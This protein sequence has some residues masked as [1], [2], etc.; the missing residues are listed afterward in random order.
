MSPTASRQEPGVEARGLAAEL[1]RRVVHEGAYANILWGHLLDRSSLAGRERAL[2]TDLAYGTIRRKGS[3]EWL[4]GRFLDR[5]PPRT[6]HA[7]LL[8][9]AYQI[10]FSAVP[11]HAAVSL[12]VEATPKRWKP[13]VNAVLRKVANRDDSWPD[14]ATELSY[15]Q[16]ILDVLG[17]DLGEQD[18]LDALRAMNDAPA[19]R[20]RNDG[21]IQDLSSEWVADAV[22]VAEGS[23]VVDLCAAPGGKATALANRK[24]RVLAVDRSRARLALVT[25]NARRVGY[26]SL[27]VTQADGRHPPLR[28]QRA[29]AV[30]VDAPCSGLGALRRRPDAR[31]RVEPH[32]VEEL[33][34][35]QGQLLA[36]A[37]DLVQ[38]GGL[39]VY[40]V[41]TLTDEET[42]QVHGAVAGALDGWEVLQPPRRWR[43]WGS[44]AAVLPQDHGTDGMYLLRLRRPG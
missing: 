4:T 43:Q 34:A 13:L 6:V 42:T 38:P 7:L 14:L 20:S 1:V 44:G 28:R 5:R 3:C 26:A 18:A 8:V 10:Q 33:A 27:P 21:Y 37:A 23:T 11:A 16:W 29:G 41:C 31:W 22:E 30:L 39:L 36:A 32:D 40:S 35:L 12:T 24:M 25:E 15:P 17:R 9:G 19:P 2:A